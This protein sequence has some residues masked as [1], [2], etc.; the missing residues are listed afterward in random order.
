MQDT[1]NTKRPPPF[2]LRL[3]P[4]ERQQLERRAAGT[5]LGA[6][7]RACLFGEGDANPAI[8]RRTRSKFPVKDHK[9]LAHVLSQL[10]ASRLASNLN[11]LAKAVNTGSLP[12][13]PE[14]ESDL[15]AAC[16]DIR[17]IKHMLMT[18]LGIQER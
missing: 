13:S 7:I 2:S 11:Q 6:Y 4:E 14:T 1:D 9:A 8:K 12:V 10:G 3:T 5:S 15:Q 17:A 18:A 16:R